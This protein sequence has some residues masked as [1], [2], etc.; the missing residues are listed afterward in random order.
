MTLF[1]K[2]HSDSKPEKIYSTCFNYVA[3]CENCFA[4]AYKSDT[5]SRQFNLSESVFLNLT[6]QIKFVRLEMVLLY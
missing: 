6:D 3:F 5:Q 1:T 2:N 4:L